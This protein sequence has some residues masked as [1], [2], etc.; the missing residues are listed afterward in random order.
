LAKP[1]ICVEINEASY[2]PTDLM[3]YTLPYVVS[4]MNTDY[5]RASQ[6]LGMSIFLAWLFWLTHKSGQILLS[7]VL[8]AFG[9]RLYDITY[10][11]PADNTVRT[12]RALAR[13]TI[14][15]GSLIGHVTIQD[16][17]ILG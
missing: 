15:A 16:I 8:I 10:K 4:F 7:P 5:D 17:M 11:F 1:K 14:E 2:V 3:N 13:T 9:W 12:G 6:F